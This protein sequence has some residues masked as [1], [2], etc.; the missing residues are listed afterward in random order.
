MKKSLYLILLLLLA[1]TGC[2][3]PEPTV[4]KN[5]RPAWILDPN[6]NGKI[7]AVGTA[8]RHHKGFTYQRKLAVSRAIDE[9]ALQQ[10]VKVTLSI[11]K[12]EQVKND[13]VKSQMNIK[14]SYDAKKSVVTAHIEETW[15]DP[16][17]QEFYVWLVKD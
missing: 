13:K 3:Q 7:G 1:F 17:S 8:N 16:I 11:K 12:Q 10:G 2:N 14:S 6:Q 15:K 9:L 5:A 4:S